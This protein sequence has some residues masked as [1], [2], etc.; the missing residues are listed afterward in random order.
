MNI[1]D[2][3]SNT[4]WQEASNTI[5]NNNNK[6]SL[7][8]A[9]LENAK[10]KNKGYFTTLEKLNEAIPNPTIGSKA[11]VG[12]S[13]P[14][15]IYIVEN[16]TWVDSGY[17]GGDETVAKI[18]TDRIEDGAVTTEKI[19]TS[20]FDPTLSV[21]G[22]ISPADVVGGKLTE[23]DD[24]IHDI[25]QN[26]LL[27]NSNL[28]PY[29]V[30]L[31][32]NFK[33]KSI[34]LNAVTLNNSGKYIV[35]SVK[36]E[37]ELVKQFQLYTSNANYG[38]DTIIE[39]NYGDEIELVSFY[40]GTIINESG[41]D[42]LLNNTSIIVVTK[43][44]GTKNVMFDGVGFFNNDG[45]VSAV[46]QYCH[47]TE[48]VKI[49]NIKDI[50]ITLYQ[51]AYIVLYNDNKEVVGSFTSSSA[52]EN[53]TLES[54]LSRV[55]TTPNASYV[56]F[57]VNKSQADARVVYSIA[58]DPS[59]DIELI[60]SKVSDL[61]ERV[62]SIEKKLKGIKLSFPV[63][64]GV[65]TYVTNVVS[66]DK[67]TTSKINFRKGDEITLIVEQSPSEI[68]NY[69]VR[70]YKDENNYTQLLS[71]TSNTKIAKIIIPDDGAFLRI[72][73]TGSNTFTLTSDGIDSI[74]NS[75]VRKEYT[76]KIINCLGDSITYGV[77]DTSG[78]GGW[79]SLISNYT[80]GTVNNCGIGGSTIG[81]LTG[82]SGSAGYF[83][84]WGRISADT[85][86]W[87]NG[88]GTPTSTYADRVLDGN[89]AMNIVFGGVNDFGQGVPIGEFLSED[90]STFKGAYNV[91]LKRLI[92]RMPNSKIAVILPMKCKGRSEA[93]IE[94]NTLNPNSKGLYE[95][96]YVDAIIEIC[97]YYSI[98]YLDLYNAS[99]ISP[100][101]GSQET[102]FF[103]DGLHP[104]HE[105][106]E[107]LA[108][109]IGEWINSF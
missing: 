7:A 47:N 30:G 20:A 43:E 54:L 2:I 40:D 75:C 28:S 42:I 58:Y 100:F 50:S 46:E 38:Y 63:S 80:G 26:P 98:P 55:Q 37:D 35:L 107:R 15:A 109:R 93:T 56:R 22:K 16:G 87:V 91:M 88:S 78:A 10:L 70:L 105:G 79:V 61:G 14:Y 64:A 96:D 8:I 106:Y 89:A 9:T 31:K 74:I 52:T 76:N 32:T 44:D 6:I 18:T 66:L 69:N 12:T 73:C 1:Q 101:F 48:F 97:N 90:C 25:Y 86:E 82:A 34:S 24:K 99:G 27:L 62:D 60:K 83:P 67:P 3:K 53:I 108:K 13:E 49:S 57:S 71:N 29:L 17:T 72:T 45:S 23:L 94:Y 5:N 19:A 36:K 4:T 85:I 21:S 77:G 39:S 68:Q 92:E 59:Q 81:G 41:L 11:Y 84:M 65:Y 33:F 102:N 103:V 104:N 51:G 95:K